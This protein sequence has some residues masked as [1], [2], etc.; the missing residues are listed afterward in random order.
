LRH[1]TPRVGAG[2]FVAILFPADELQKRTTRRLLLSLSGGNPGKKEQQKSQDCP[3]FNVTELT[4]EEFTSKE[5]ARKLAKAQQQHRNLVESNRRLVEVSRINFDFLANMSHELRA[6][7][8]AVIGFSEVLQDQTFGQ[9]NE[10]QKEYVS[11]ILSSGRRLLTLIDDILDLS[12]LESGR[13]TLELSNFSLHESLHDS[14]MMLK[15]KAFKNRIALH[16]DL[17]TQAD[18]SISADQRKL[19]RVMFN[20]LSNAVWFTPAGGSQKRAA[21]QLTTLSHWWKP[22]LAQNKPSISGE[23]HASRIAECCRKYCRQKGER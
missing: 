1:K 17:D 8:N 12:T 22:P 15:E 14:L 20:L 13:M 16:L 11:S 7:L 19:K 10:Q 5:L 23:H 6:P 18:V 21:C 9:I 2:I 4:Q 3:E